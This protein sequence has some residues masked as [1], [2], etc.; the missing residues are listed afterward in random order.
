VHDLVYTPS[1]YNSGNAAI[2]IL[3]DHGIHHSE[4]FYTPPGLFANKLP[5]GNIL[6]PKKYLNSHPDEFRRLTENT[7]HLVTPFDL[8]ATVQYWLTGRDWSAIQGRHVSSTASNFGKSL[9]TTEIESNRNC[10]MAGI[11]SFFCG[12]NMVPC[13]NKVSNLVKAEKAQIIE[14]INNKISLSSPQT[15]PVCRPLD[16]NDFIHISDSK[17]SC[18][19]RPGYIQTDIYLSRNRY[20]LSVIFRR[21]AN[22]LVVENVNTVSL[23]G[24]HWDVCAEKLQKANIFNNITMDRF[25]FC[26]CEEEESFA[27]RS[28]SGLLNMLS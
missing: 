25:Q 17:T 8:R 15:L 27:I 12:C 1:K 19:E 16:F 28:I 3:S 9:M 20:K 4:E 22:A 24:S 21:Y 14:F 7:K 10:E 11:P 5:F 6:L 23:Y 2:L 26:Y 18:Y 13:S